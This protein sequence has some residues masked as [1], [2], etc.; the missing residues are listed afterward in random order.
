MWLVVVEN[1]PT[2]PTP[3]T[4]TKKKK[5]ANNQNNDSY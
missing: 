5:T 3:T 1:D 4:I 2:V